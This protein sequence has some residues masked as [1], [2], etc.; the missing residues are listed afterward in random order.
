M[1]LIDVDALGVGRCSRDLLPA[2][3][4]AG[5]NGLIRLL[6][7]APTVDAV[8]VVHARWI[9]V[10]RGDAMQ[11]VYR[12]DKCSHCGNVVGFGINLRYCHNCGARMD[13]KEPTNE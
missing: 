2:D 3:Y 7:K 9:R 13:G 5:W 12:M 4:C 10:L 6:A 11:T 1:R 8:P